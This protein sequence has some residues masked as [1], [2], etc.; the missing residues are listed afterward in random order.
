M[1][2]KGSKENP[3]SADEFKKALSAIKPGTTIIYGGNIKDD[4]CSYECEIFGKKGISFPHKINGKDRGIIKDDMKEAFG[5][6]RVH[7]AVIDDV[8]H[9]SKIE[10]TNI[11]DMHNHD[12]T[13]L[14][15]VTEFKVK[16]GD[17]NESVILIGNKRTSQGHRI[18]IEGPKIPIDN[19]SSYQWYNELKDAVNECRMEVKLY[20]EG[21]FIPVKQKENEE[22]NPQQ[23][24]IGDGNVTVEMVPADEFE[25]GAVE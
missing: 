18:E 16:G 20:H 23:L 21:K 3:V 4:F 6:L 25:K 17:E 10:V 11:D 12:L 24:T 15:N 22:P 8:F 2:R 5:K 13:Q 9:Y 7:L 19:L 1:A 14:Y